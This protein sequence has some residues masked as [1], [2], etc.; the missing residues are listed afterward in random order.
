MMI[1]K[2]NHNMKSVDNVVTSWYSPSRTTLP[3]SELAYVGKGRVI[4]VLCL[5][6]TS[7]VSMISEYPNESYREVPI[8]GMSMDFG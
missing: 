7:I 4:N 3:L 5:I 1:L 6:H 2:V 8:K